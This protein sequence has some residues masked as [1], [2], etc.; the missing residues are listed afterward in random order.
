MGSNNTHREQS[1]ER[2]SA[3][4][5]GSGGSWYLLLEGLARLVQKYHPHLQLQVVEGGGVGNHR[6]VG[7]GEMPIAILNPPMTVAALAGGE[8]FDRSYPDLRVGVAN[9][10]TNHLHFV[11][12]QS[13]P[14]DSLPQWFANR[15]PL[16][17]PVDRTSTVDRLVFRLA[18]RHYGVSEDAVTAWG[19]RLFPANNYHEQLRLYQAGEVNALWQFMGI[20]SPSIQAAH[21][22]RPIRLL[23][24][25]DSLIDQLQEMGWNRATIPAGAYG[26]VAEPVATVSMGTSLGFHRSVPDDMVFAIVSTICQQADEV[27]QIHPASLDFDPS[28]AATNPGGPLHPGAIRYYQSHGVAIH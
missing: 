13:T 4:A 21:Q 1:P 10:T 6:Q 26:I 23:P 5:G 28:L 11:A 3:A 2:L 20:P 17:V 14:L 9:L 24:L 7:L 22:E 25:G 15:Y 12:E 18:L 19:S 27:R 16:R 8:P